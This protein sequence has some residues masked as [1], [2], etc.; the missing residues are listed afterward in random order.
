MVSSA[1]AAVLPDGLFT[2]VRPACFAEGRS[3]LST[4][5]PARPMHRS[6]GAPAATVAALTVFAERTITAEKPGIVLSR[7][8][9]EIL[10]LVSISHPAV[11][12][13]YVYPCNKS[14]NCSASWI[15]PCVCC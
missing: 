3:M 14:Y 13:A 7:V 1:T 15:V 6:E 5:A 12:S 8:S 4:P 2:T 11:R 9:S 10:D